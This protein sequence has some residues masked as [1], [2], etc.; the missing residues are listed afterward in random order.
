MY[1]Y[2]LCLTKSDSVI[3]SVGDIA[4]YVFPTEIYVNQSEKGD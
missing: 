1:Y 4:K 3:I 2:I